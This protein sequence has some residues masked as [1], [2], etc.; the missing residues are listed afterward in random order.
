VHHVKAKEKG[1]KK[2]IR[3]IRSYSL[4]ETGHADEVERQMDEKE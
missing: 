1:G 4:R 3:Q 2:I